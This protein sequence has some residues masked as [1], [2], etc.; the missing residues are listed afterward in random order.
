MSPIR[1]P[2]SLT[3]NHTTERQ[4]DSLHAELSA[5]YD[6][7]ATST[8]HQKDH[9]TDNRDRTEPAIY[10]CAELSLQVAAAGRASAS[11]AR[12]RVVDVH[13]PDQ[14]QNNANNTQGRRSA[15]QGGESADE[16]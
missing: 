1:G 16:N 7:S 4:T 6:L 5:T 10:I 11:V 13:Q 12:L 14:N 3:S 8:R 9:A 2:S 15:D